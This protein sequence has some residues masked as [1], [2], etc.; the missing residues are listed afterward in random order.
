MQEHNKP[1]YLYPFGINWR[2]ALLLCFAFVFAKE[3]SQ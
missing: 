3:V 2:L 1:S